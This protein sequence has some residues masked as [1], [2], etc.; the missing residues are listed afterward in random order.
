MDHNESP[1]QASS[2]PPLRIHHL[3]AW[4][5]GTSVVASLWF[6]LLSPAIRQMMDAWSAALQAADWTLLGTSLTIVLFG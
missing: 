3:F 2:L 6:A 5:T 4:I 1:A